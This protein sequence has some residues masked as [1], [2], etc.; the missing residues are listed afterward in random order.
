M[1]YT[2]VAFGDGNTRFYQGDTGA[3]GAEAEAWPAQLEAI[4]L[5]LGMKATVRNA[6]F[7][8]EPAAFG[9]ARFEQYAGMADLC[10]VGFG[11]EDIR[12]ME[13]TMAFYLSEMED[14]LYQAKALGIK[15]IVLGIP[16][17]DENWGGAVAQTRLPKW[18]AALWELC[19]RHGVPFLDLNA[20]FRDDPERWYGERRTPRRSLSAAGQRRLAQMVLPLVMVEFS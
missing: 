20:A 19:D 5:A 17:F 10:V 16:W 12:H 2:I 15:L 11:L 13:R 1:D 9:R 4:M 18:N 6:G 7:P 3:C 8:G 14:I